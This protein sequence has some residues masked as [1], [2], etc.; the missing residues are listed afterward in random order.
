MKY[1]GDSSNESKKS[2]Y[3]TDVFVVE[4]KDKNKR[5]VVSY[6]NG[7][8]DSNVKYISEN[9]EKLNERLCVQAKEVIMDRAK[10]V[11][12]KKQGV[13]SRLGVGIS[14][15]VA[16]PVL[17]V[18]TIASYSNSADSIMTLCAAGAIAIGGVILT[19]KGYQM[20]K[21]YD[22]IIQEIDNVNFRLSN[23]EEAQRYLKTSPNAY[24]SLDGKNE[25]EKINRAGM[26]FDAM[27]QEKDPFS[28]LSLETGEG[29]TNEEMNRLLTRRA[30]EKTLGL[31]YQGGYS[32]QDVVKGRGNK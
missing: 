6:A 17:A 30:R 23:S 21:K 32:Y 26:L 25:E 9:A 5:Y 10:L 24:L 1:Y 16:G 29:V 12:K 18:N 2:T 27:Y 4:N 20:K 8:Q 7:D 31:V 11:Q 19:V 22:E 3:I 13:I 14:C 28:L 15:F